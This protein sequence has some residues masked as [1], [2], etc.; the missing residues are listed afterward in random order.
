MNRTAIV[1]LALGDVGVAPNVVSWDE[2][3]TQAEYAR[4]FWDHAVAEALHSHT[5]RFAM[6]EVQLQ[7]LVSTPLDT[8]TYAFALPAD[9]VVLDRVSDNA[10]FYPPLQDYDLK[11][12]ADTMCIVSS[13]EAVYIE[14]VYNAPAIAF[15][16]RYF[17]GVVSAMLAAP[18]SNVLKTIRQDL[19]KLI[20]TRVA[21][22]KSLDSFAL[23]PRRPP[24]TSWQR[25][26]RGGRS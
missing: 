13:S 3:S 23:P 17:Q 22:A 1:N 20:Q 10:S 24:M 9:Y 26:M 21:R 6:K 11:V 2:D 7:R 16:P 15:W 14:Y 4:Q 8:N 5:W 18:L 19:D 25:A 12:V